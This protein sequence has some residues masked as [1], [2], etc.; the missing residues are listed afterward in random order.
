MMVGMVNVSDSY[1]YKTNCHKFSGWKQHAFIIRSVWAQFN[2]GFRVSGYY[3]PHLGQ[4]GISSVSSVEIC[5]P[6][7][8][9]AIGNIYFKCLHDQGLSFLLE[10][11]LAQRGYLCFLGHGNSNM[12][13]TS[14]QLASSSQQGGLSNT[15]ASDVDFTHIILTVG[16]PQ[17]LWYV[18]LIAREGRRLYKIMN[19]SKQ[20]LLG[21]TLVSIHQ[22]G[23]L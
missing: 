22:H 17:H 1:C 11:A 9:Q 19:S 14:W 20:E 16:T 7:L 5:G 6:E 2:W 10:N 21:V 3:N 23:L 18:S 8:I 15:L 4:N 12:A 13:S